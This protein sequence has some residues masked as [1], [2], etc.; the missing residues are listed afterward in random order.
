MLSK[1]QIQEFKRLLEERRNALLVEI[2]QELLNSDNEQYVAL[3]GQVHDLEEQS[4]AD[5]LVDINLAVIDRHIIQLRDVE[6]ALQRIAQGTYGRCI[7]SG[8]PIPIERLKAMPTAK[9]TE[10]AQER[11]EQSHAG[12]EHARL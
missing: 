7:D 1:E 2:R 8:E 6:E 5:L 11:Y 9:R 12:A 4:V 3:A 10:Q